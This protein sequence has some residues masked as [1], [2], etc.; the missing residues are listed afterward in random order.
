MID[1]TMNVT[2]PNDCLRNLDI[3]SMAHGLQIRLTFLGARVLDLA[4]RLPHRWKH[5]GRKRNK[6]LLRK[7]LKRYV[8]REIA[9]R[10]SAAF[11]IPLET[12]LDVEKRLAIEEMLT[13]RD[14]S[15]RVLIDENNT[16]RICVAFVRGESPRSHGAASTT[17]STSACSGLWSDGCRSGARRRDGSGQGKKQDVASGQD[18]RTPERNTWDFSGRVRKHA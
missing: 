13:R 12:S 17:I 7:M 6:L 5:P 3:M 10:R 11:G 4:A 14:A 16:S 9:A 8:P 15:I 2:L 1:V 18:P